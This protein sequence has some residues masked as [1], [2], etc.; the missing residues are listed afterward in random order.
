MYVELILRPQRLAD[1]VIYPDQA[2]KL[3]A[4]AIGAHAPEQARF[5]RFLGRDGQG[6]TL[7]GRIGD[8][9]NGEGFGRAPE[10]AFDGGRGFIRVYGIGADGGELLLS[11]A[12][13]LYRAVASEHGVTQQ[14]LQQGDCEI[15]FKGFM[16]PHRIRLMVAC[17]RPGDRLEGIESE[18]T[19]ALLR[20]HIVGGL[21]SQS[22]LLGMS[23]RQV[24]KDSD[25]EILEG[26]PYP[27]PIRDHVFASGLKDVVFAMPCRLKGP[28]LA[29]HLRSRG[30]GFMRA[31]DP[32]RSSR[33]EV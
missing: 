3:I 27:V 5:Q 26:R 1:Q 7:Q 13:D 10:I 18:R 14:Q 24:P 17:K 4:A 33:Q 16:V 25:V 28:W 6:K 22:E 29:G 19:A 21:V 9:R 11:L 32:T 12:T 23:R 30:Y 2:R 31:V 20:R 15:E 8:D